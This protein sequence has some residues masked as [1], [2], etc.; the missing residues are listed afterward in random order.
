MNLVTGATGIVGSHIVSELLQ[1]EEPVRVLLRKNSSKQAI[2]QLL[3]FD[4][5]LHQMDTIEWFEG[6]IND[7][8]SLMEAVKGCERV[9][10]SAALVSF[11][12]KDH[13]ELFLVNAEGTGH[14][15]NACLEQGVKELYYISSTAAIGDETID[16]KLTEQSAWTTDKG[17]SSYSLSK[18]HAEM[19]VWRGIQEGLNTIMVNPGI[20]IGPGKWGQ[21]S[22]T[23]I[24]SCDSG[25]RF[26]P[27]GANGFVDARD[28]VKALFFLRE[29][30]RWNERYLLI[31]ESLDY[32][33]FFTKVCDQLGTT[34][35]QIEL[36]K[37]VVRPIIKLI[38]W[39]EWAH[40]N[41][42]PLT[43]E[44]LKSAYRKAVYS[45]EKIEKLGFE[46]TSMGDSIEY[47]LKVRKA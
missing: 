29:Q 34:K 40:I 6:D 36:S 11:R 5:R 30:E 31:G 12:R 24:T 28:I 41:P 32:Q 47:T 4:N 27:S 21:S 43:S 26:Y 15:V 38:E 44:N 33:T 14:V 20:I 2:E 17:R 39:L 13:S 37:S 16:G 25:M 9:Y 46:F 8:L 42:L 23:M 10:H 19:A 45:A 1:R 18:R 35:P 7:P 22:T 3:R